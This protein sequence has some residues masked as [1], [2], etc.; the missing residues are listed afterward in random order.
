[1]GVWLLH[2]HPLSSQLRLQEAAWHILANPH[3]NHPHHDHIWWKREH[4][5]ENRK[6]ESSRRVM[7]LLLLAVPA[8][9]YGHVAS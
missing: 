4:F 3:H 8:R 1:M 5:G 6:A 9:I 7:L 2:L